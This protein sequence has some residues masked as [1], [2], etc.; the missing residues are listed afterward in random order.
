MLSHAPQTHFFKMARRLRDPAQS[1]ACRHLPM[2]PPIPPLRC[3]DLSVGQPFRRYRASK[4]EKKR[5]QAV[6]IGYFSRERIMCSLFRGNTATKKNFLQKQLRRPLSH[7]SQTCY[8]K[9]A[10]RLRDPAQSIACRHSPMA[11][12]FPRL[13][14]SDLSV[15]QPFRRYRATKRE[16]KCLQ[17]VRIGY[18]SKERI[19]CSLF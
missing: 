18:F 2:P 5:L 16:K 1:I 8:F 19:L 11:P 12:P 6:R 3:S 10:G 4:K 14:C 9:I 7:A 15:G 17:P 13:R